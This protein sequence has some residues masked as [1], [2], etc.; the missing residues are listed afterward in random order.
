MPEYNGEGNPLKPPPENIEKANKLIEQ[1]NEL[2][3]R[4]NPPP[5]SMLKFFRYDHLPR[6]LREVSFEFSVLANT[7]ANMAVVDERERQVALRKLL[8]A[9]DAAVRSVIP[10]D[11]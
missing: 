9:K 10:E 8:E 4:K 7:V 3:R 1:L 5:D 2:E 11:M 6:I